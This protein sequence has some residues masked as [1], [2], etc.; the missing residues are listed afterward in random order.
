MTM[1]LLIN[2]LTKFIC[3]LLLVDLLIF[4]PAGTLQYAYGWLF[5]GLLFIPMLIAGFVMFFKSPDF[6]AK[7][8]DAKEKQATQKGVVAL[9]GLMFIGVFVVAGLDYRF[10]WSQMHT[11]VTVVASVLFLV[12]YALYAEVM[13]E[14][15]YLSRTIKVEQGQTVVDTGLYGIVRHPMYMATI[16]LFLMI[17]VVLGSWYALIPMA[18][19]PAIIIV[20]LKDEEALLT[21]ELSGY[22]EYKKKVKYRIIPFIW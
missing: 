6:L 19:Y 9:S 16:L 3:G 1:K 4:L 13:R 7:R 14:N 18:F 12:A 5:V 22:E 20:R 15:A 11:A 17:P 8:L 2:A 10:G 21:R